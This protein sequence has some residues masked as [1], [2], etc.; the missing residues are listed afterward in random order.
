MVQT[1][2]ISRNTAQRSYD[3]DL[4]ARVNQ[5][6]RSAVKGPL[7]CEGQSIWTLLRRDKNKQQKHAVLYKRTL[8]LDC[9]NK[10]DTY[11]LATLNTQELY[12]HIIAAN[13][14]RG[15]LGP[16][17]SRRSRSLASATFVFFLNLVPLTKP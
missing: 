3:V 11:A 17:A 1:F 2:V 8:Q 10:P 14:R 12:T 15:L 9:T 13:Q 6:G 16:K 5:Y 7:R 4:A